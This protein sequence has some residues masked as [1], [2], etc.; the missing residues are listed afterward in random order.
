VL[1]SLS[2]GLDE[3]PESPPPGLVT[4]PNLPDVPAE[5]TRDGRLPPAGRAR[6]ASTCW[7]GWPTCCAAE[8]AAR[9]FEAKA[10]MLSITG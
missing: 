5:A 9:G 6:S 10:D 3:F 2:Q 7:S 1:W 8:T 4:I